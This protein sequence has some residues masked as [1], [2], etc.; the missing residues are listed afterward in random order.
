MKQ[1]AS[2]SDSFVPKSKNYQEN[3]Q[4]VEV[5]HTRAR[6]LTHTNEFTFVQSWVAFVRPEQDTGGD[7]TGLTHPSDCYTH[8][9]RPD[10]CAVTLSSVWNSRFRSWAALGRSCWTGW[11]WPPCTS[12]AALPRVGPSSAS[13]RGGAC[14]SGPGWRRPGWRGGQHPW[15]RGSEWAGTFPF[16]PVKTH[17]PGASSPVWA[18]PQWFWERRELSRPP[19]GWG[20]SPGS[21]KDA[22]TEMHENVK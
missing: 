19:R 13:G 3:S 22:K 17:P 6:T 16:P 10:R 4:Y 14:C 20:T 8:P 12:P 5:Q 18:A 9:Q 7:W 15:R 11:S 21:G 1:V 2:L